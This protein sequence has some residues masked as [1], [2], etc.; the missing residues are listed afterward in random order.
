MFKA[1]QT[2]AACLAALLAL[3]AAPAAG[4]R[5]HPP[6]ERLTSVEQVQ[7]LADTSPV[8]VLAFVP[9]KN[10]GALQALTKLAAVAAKAHGTQ[11][12]ADETSLR[13]SHRHSC[14]SPCAWQVSR[15][16]GPRT[17]PCSPSTRAAA[18]TATRRWLCSPS[19]PPPTRAASTPATSRRRCS[20]SG[21]PAGPPLLCRGIASEP[22]A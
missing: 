8:S 22:A 17:A 12:T 19:A 7:T 21:P 6:P 1:W 4:W 5:G 10:S 13:C 3:L 18:P 11:A 14:Q 20:S 16:Y 2:H 15:L 9:E